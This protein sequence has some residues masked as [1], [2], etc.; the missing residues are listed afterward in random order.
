MS[1]G[2]EGGVA[3]ASRL[4]PVEYEHLVSGIREV[5]HRTL[6]LNATV[7]VVSRGDDEL[8]QLGPRQALHFPQDEDG[9]YAGYYPS[10]SEAAIA[11]VESLREAKGAEYLLLPATAYWWLEYYDGFKRHLEQRYQ[12]V[13]SNEHCWIVHLA[14]RTEVD[15][16]TTFKA[17]MPRQFDLANPTR[18]VLEGLLPAGA[19]I[20]FLS[21]GAEHPGGF[22]GLK[23]WRPPKEAE[24]DRTAAIESLNALV[25]SGIQFVVVPRAA[26]DWLDDQPDL[27]ECLRARHRFVTRQER[28]CEIYEMRPRAAEGSLH[29]SESS[30]TSTRSFGEIL[31]GILFPSRRNDTP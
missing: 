16:K 1:L 8:L 21:V 12:V 19:R 11:M 14:E 15:G 3:V 7:L 24:T 5:V 2:T 31:R 29:E 10:D 30:N 9:R 13:E 18:E 6:P 4:S 23:A 27:L 26:F 28:L 25:E 20:A 17:D 22:D